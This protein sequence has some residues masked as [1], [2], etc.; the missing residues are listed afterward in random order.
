VST[1]AEVSGPIA[2]VSLIVEAC[3]TPAGTRRNV[4]TV[5]ATAAGTQQRPPKFDVAAGA[6]IANRGRRN[7]RRHCEQ[8]APRQGQDGRAPVAGQLSPT[9]PDGRCGTGRGRE[10]SQ[11]LASLQKNQLRRFGSPSSAYQS[12]VLPLILIVTAR[13]SLN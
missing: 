4:F 13:D 5:M 1:R 8:H 10:R 9:D 6:V 3:S 11:P 12:T 2:R 7:L